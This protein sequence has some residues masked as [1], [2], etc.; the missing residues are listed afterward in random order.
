[1]FALMFCFVLFC[2]VLCWLIIEC[3]IG[4]SHIFFLFKKFIPYSKR[5][6][7]PQDLIE[8]AHQPEYPKRHMSASIEDHHTALESL[9][10]SSEIL[11][12]RPH[13]GH[14]IRLGDA[15]ISNPAKEQNRALGELHR[16]ARLHRQPQDHPT[17]QTHPTTSNVNSSV[18]QPHPANSQPF[19]RPSGLGSKDLS[20]NNW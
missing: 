12:L 3:L 14:G 19:F 1:M 8:T 13:I 17:N 20:W 16:L 11:T 9:S 10:P 18:I 15:T 7:E 4:R 5:H 2:F 6:R